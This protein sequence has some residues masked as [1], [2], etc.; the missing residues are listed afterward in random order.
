MRGFFRILT[1]FSMGI[2]VHVEILHNFA[3]EIRIT[4]C[5][6]EYENKRTY[7]KQRL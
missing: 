2:A 6:I 5:Y 3:I 7:K 4:Y 1:Y